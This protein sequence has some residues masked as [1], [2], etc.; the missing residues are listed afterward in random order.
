M[1]YCRFSNEDWKPFPEEFPDLIFPK[2]DV[3]VFDYCYGGVMCCGCR[4]VEPNEPSPIFMKYSEMI[5][6]LE[7][8]IKAGHTVP[9]HVIPNLQLIIYTD[10]DNVPPV[11]IEDGY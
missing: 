9:G 5:V 3:Y 4:L 8:H 11:S 7:K 10:G 1:S 2:S 6:H